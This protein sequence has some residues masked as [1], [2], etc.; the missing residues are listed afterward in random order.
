MSSRMHPRPRHPHITIKNAKSSERKGKHTS[1][2]AR[3]TH[4]VLVA[5]LDEVPVEVRLN[6]PPLLLEHDHFLIEEVGQLVMVPV[7]A[8]QK[9]TRSATD[10]PGCRCPS[11][12]RIS[13]F[14]VRTPQGRH[15]RT[16][17]L[18]SSSCFAASSFSAFWLANASAS[19]CDDEDR[20]A[21]AVSREIR[22][23]VGCVAP[24]KMWT[25]VVF[26]PFAPK[27]GSNVPPRLR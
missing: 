9:E 12:A 19:T 16:Y 2:R 15:A 23:E 25:S 14:L 8:R 3:D 5:P 17:L 4:L 1:P 26:H 22:G 21:A 20:E 27:S 7:A 13:F 11:C 18:K 10:G 6:L 24:P